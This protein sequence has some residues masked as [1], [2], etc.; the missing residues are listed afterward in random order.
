MDKLLAIEGSLVGISCDA[1]ANK[2]WSTRQVSPRAHL[3]LSFAV[4]G[5][6]FQWKQ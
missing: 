3:L 4:G 5:A 2:Y 6:T 1:V